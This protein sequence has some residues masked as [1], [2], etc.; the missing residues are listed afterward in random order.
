MREYYIFLSNG[1]KIEEPIWTE[2]YVDAFIEEDVISVTF[3][4]YFEEEGT[5][6]RN[7]LG[8]ASIDLSMN[9]LA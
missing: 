3:P 8:V 7:L 4:I 1:I 9:Y 5:S 6:I 2:P